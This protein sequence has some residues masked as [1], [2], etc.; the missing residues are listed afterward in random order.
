MI[1]VEDLTDISAAE[2]AVLIALFDRL[3][4]PHIISE[5]HYMISSDLQHDNAMVQKIFDDFIFPYV[6]AK[7][8]SVTNVHVRSDGCKAQFKCASNFFWVSRQS[9]EGSGLF[10]DWSFFESCHGKCYC[11]PEGGTLKSAAD[12]HELNISDPAQQLRDSEALYL[13]ARDQSGL[14]RPRRTLQ[15]KKGKGIFR[16]FFCFVPSKG[17]GAVDRSRLVKYNAEGTSKLHEFIDIGVPGK[18][19]TRRAACHQCDNCWA[20]DRANCENKEYV[21]PPTELVI[22]PA[23]AAPAAA[24]ERMARAAVGRAGLERARAATVDSIVCIETHKDEQSHP[25]VI[26]RVIRALHDAPAPAPAYDPAIH[27]V[28][29]DPVRAE[30]E[31]LEVRLYEA[32]Q[33]GS[34][35]YTLSELVVVVAAR[36]IRVV[37]VDFQEVRSSTRLAGQASAAA[38]V[39]GSARGGRMQLSDE[40]LLAIRAEMPTS[41]DDWEVEAV[42]EYRVRYGTEQWLLKW[43]GYGPDRN[44]WE[45]WEHLITEQVEGE[46]RQV[47]DGMVSRADE[48]GLM[49]LTLVTLKAVLASKGFD[50]GGRVKA[51][52]VQRLLAARASDI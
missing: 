12:R 16:R 30:D 26:G 46:A 43:K 7:A 25:W 33:P 45:P 39:A 18:V 49:K 29:L 3:G 31:C 27:A 22:R 40:S 13:W 48:A 32:L 5:T 28:R 50:S 1:R 42:L 52:L 44:T 4:L 47:R 2:K 6:S 14:S 11:D 38:A 15:E 10:V 8:P 21:G 51:E 19:S 20:G 34:T 24:E 35:T 41:S 23:T 37:G 36:A 9:A 17:N